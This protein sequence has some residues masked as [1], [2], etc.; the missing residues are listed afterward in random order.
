M[1][2]IFFL[3]YIVRYICYEK[4]LISFLVNKKVDFVFIS[5]DFYEG[6]KY[7]QVFIFIKMCYL[8]KVVFCNIEENDSFRSAQFDR[9]GQ[10]F[11]IYYGF[12]NIDG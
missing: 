10:Y 11:F 8:Y 7:C 4:V 12:W 9:N 6:F 2:L 1:K 3:I 5:F